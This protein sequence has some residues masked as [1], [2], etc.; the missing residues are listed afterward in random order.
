MNLPSFLWLWK[1]AA[2]S[3]GCS[4]FAYFVLAMTGGWMLYSRHSKQPRPKGLRT[5]H[6]FVG[7]GMVCLVLALLAIGLVGTLGYY[8]SL[9]HSIHLAAGLI[10]VSLVL[11]SAWSATQI[12]PKNPWARSLHISLNIGL[13]FAF[14][15]VSLSGWVI[16]Q[17]YL[18]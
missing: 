5:L 12:N 8:G 7:G 13:F 11:G 14:T 15:A 1:I 2:W 3:M 6:Y 16:V 17:K 18:P 10:V 4:V 9:G